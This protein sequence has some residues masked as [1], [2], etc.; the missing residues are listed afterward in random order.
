[1][2][3]NAEDTNKTN[4]ELKPSQQLDLDKNVNVTRASRVK[5]IRARSL[6]SLYYSA[7]GNVTP[8]KYRVVL[9]LSMYKKERANSFVTVL[10]YYIT[11]Q[12]INCLLTS[13]KQ[14]CRDFS[15]RSP[16]A[17]SSSQTAL[18]WPLSLDSARTTPTSLS[19][20]LQN[21]TLNAP[22]YRAPS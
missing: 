13:T 19:L 7:A 11:V 8:L 22:P 4:A 1:M 15:N 2:I 5:K 3:A 21:T 17:I 14:I 6:K 10:I 12:L 9:V 20:S 16:W 18:S